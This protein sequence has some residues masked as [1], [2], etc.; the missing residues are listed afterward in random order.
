ML[1]NVT[2]PSNPRVYSASNKNE[3][4]KPKIA[5][6]GSKARPALQ[7]DKPSTICEP[8]VL[9]SVGSSTSHN[10]MRLHGLLR[11]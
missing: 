9:N 2:N 10:P 1:T 4:K 3:Y 6:P 5:Y 8:N 7:A 11:G